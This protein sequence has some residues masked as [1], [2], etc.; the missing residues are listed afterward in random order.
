MHLDG[1]FISLFTGFPV[2]GVEIFALDSVSGSSALGAAHSLSF[3]SATS[4][5]VCVG[6]RMTFST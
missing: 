2:H 1:H 3:W 6:W 5:E 4:T